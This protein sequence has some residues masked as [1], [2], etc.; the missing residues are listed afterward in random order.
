MRGKGWVGAVLTAGALG[1]AT[2]TGTPEQTYEGIGV[3]GSGG[4]TVVTAEE[5]HDAGGSVL[6]AIT[7][8]IPNMKVNYPV[9]RCPSIALR[10]SREARGGGYPDVYVDGARATN[11]CVLDTMQARDVDRVE[12]Y[13]A[14]YT[15]RPG[16]GTSTHG[17][18][19]IFSRRG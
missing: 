19:L 5:L 12:I 9:D 10:R 4:A 18:I 6:R 3:R 7:G 2:W 13:P 17:L 16:Y 11:T 1:C 8:K 14:G 15:R